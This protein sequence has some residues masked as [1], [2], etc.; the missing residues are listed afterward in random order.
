[1]AISSAFM[2]RY[3]AS[4]ALPRI[5]SRNSAGSSP[6][7]SASA[8]DC[9]TAAFIVATQALQTSLSALAAPSRSPAYT[10]RAE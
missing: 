10:E 4:E 7:P 8:T 6:R 9:P 3:G 2:C 5:A 1:M